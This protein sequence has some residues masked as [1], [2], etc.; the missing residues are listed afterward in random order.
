MHDNEE[1][2]KGGGLDQAIK[3]LAKTWKSLLSKHTNAELGVDI[4]FTRP[5]TE[6]LLEDFAK[7][8]KSC[9]CHVA[10]Q[11]KP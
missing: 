6:V 9:E 2:D 7:K 1:W 4:Q 5:A 11:W 10:F 8:V 3:L